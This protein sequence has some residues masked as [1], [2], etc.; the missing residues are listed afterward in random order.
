[1]SNNTKQIPTH[2]ISNPEGLY[3]PVPNGYSHLATVK[4]E[5]ELIFV[6]GQGGEH[7]DGTYEP[8]FR[9]QVRQAFQNVKTALQSQQSK[10]EHIVKMRM[11]IVDYDA[12]KHKILTEE[13]NRLWPDKKFPAQ[14]LIPVPKLALEEML[15]EVE[16]IEMGEGELRLHSLPGWRECPFY[17]EQEKAVLAFAEAVTKADSGGVEDQVFEP[18][19]KF[20][21]NSGI[22]DLTIGITQINTWN[23]INKGFRTTPGNYTVGQFG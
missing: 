9:K 16:A 12:Q 7:T 11:L 13:S 18:L 6:S 10:I 14:T 23:R 17:T 20:Y 22:A 8:D 5:R 21:S 1:M 3:D 19:T 15:F 4:S 2:S